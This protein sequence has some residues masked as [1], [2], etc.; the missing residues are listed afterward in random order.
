MG[1]FGRRFTAPST[2][3]SMVTTAPGAPATSRGLLV[4]GQ[5]L[6]GDCGAQ[7]LVR[8]LLGEL[9]RRLRRLSVP[10]PR[11]KSYPLVQCLKR[12]WTAP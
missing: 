11:N 12:D 4:A 10:V 2:L 5:R 8:R 9:P 3:S 7:A 1:W 6:C